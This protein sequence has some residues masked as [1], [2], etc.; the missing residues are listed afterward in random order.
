MAARAAL[1]M[2]QP[3]AKNGITTPARTIPAIS[4][5]GDSPRPPLDRP[6][7]FV[8]RLARILRGAGPYKQ[9][10]TPRI[11]ICATLVTPNRGGWA[12]SRIVPSGGG[13]PRRTK[14]GPYGAGQ[15]KN[16]RPAV[17]S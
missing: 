16:G 15:G 7:A 13:N 14:Y 6:V 2:V 11:S 1:T 4:V 9:V 17:F 10:P 8:R 5:I 12:R 3:L